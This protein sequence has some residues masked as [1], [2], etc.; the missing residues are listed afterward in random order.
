MTQEKYEARAGLFPLH[1]SSIERE[2]VPLTTQASLPSVVRLATGVR[3]HCWFL[4][5]EAEMIAQYGGRWIA[6]S[7]STLLGVAD[8]AKDAYGQAKQ[9]GVTA[10]AIMQVPEHTGEWEH[11][12]F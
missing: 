7:G 10:P 12:I 5:H 6:I 3:E 9:R 11:L 8:S 4:D 1:N 2:T